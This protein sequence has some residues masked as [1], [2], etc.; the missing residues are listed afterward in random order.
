M[1]E[2][3]SGAELQF[4]ANPFVEATGLSEI[5]R[6]GSVTR[7]LFSLVIAVALLATVISQPAT[8]VEAEVAMASMPCC[9]DDCP[10]DP[11]CDMACMVMMRCATGSVGLV[12]LLPVLTLSLAVVSDAHG[13]DPPWRVDELHPE[14][15]KRPPR[16]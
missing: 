5:A 4:T 6:M 7:A 3:K 11:A 8:A 15:F 13:A 10:Q 9:D 2:A 1:D 12:P 14:A 16:I